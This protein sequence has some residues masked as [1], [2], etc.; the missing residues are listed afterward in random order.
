MKLKGEIEMV[1]VQDQVEGVGQMENVWD[2][3]V[4]FGRFYEDEE[5]VKKGNNGFWRIDSIQPQ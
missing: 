3:D 4:S 1:E 5:E 2:H